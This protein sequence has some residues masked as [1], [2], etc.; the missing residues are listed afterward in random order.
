MTI[1]ASRGAPMNVI[2]DI[3][4]RL[5]ADQVRGSLKICRGTPYAERKIG[6]LIDCIEHIMRP[7]AVYT[8]SIVEQTV[9]DTLV[10][11]GHVFTSRVLAKNLSDQEHCYPYVVTAGRELDG[12]ELPEGQSPMLLD[13]VKNIVVEKAYQYT[14]AFIAERH[15]V[16]HVSGMSPGHLDWPLE[17]QRVLFDLL[18]PG[19]D[20]IG[21]RLTDAYLMVPVKTVSG[22]LFTSET[23]FL[24][25]R[26]CA[27]P[28]CMGRR[29]RYD[30]VVAKAYGL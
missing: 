21:V 15:G 12:M 1:K 16:E 13:L 29:V 7:K 25:C 14:R 22:V 5:E 28:R 19:V 3:P 24:S 9:L 6:E 17:Q 23:G 30:P 10:V 18:G 2:D 11:D 20:K 8:E 4:I 27:Q 26:V